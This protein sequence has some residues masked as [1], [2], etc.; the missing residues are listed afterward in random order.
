VVVASEAR[1]LDESGTP[2]QKKDGVPEHVA[3]PEGAS[4]ELYERRG[5]LARV[6]WGTTM[7]WVSL[8]Q[9]RV[10]ARP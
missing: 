6:E 5:Q 7:A 10:L 4:V 8:G 2:L 9:L 3:I 1:L